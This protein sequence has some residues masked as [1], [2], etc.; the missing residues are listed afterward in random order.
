MFNVIT[1]QFKAIFNQAIDSLIDRNGLAVP[2]KVVYDS[3]KQSLCGN[4]LFDPMQHR[5][6]NKYNG[7]GPAPF[8]NLSICPVCNGLGLIDMSAE[9]TIYIA[10]IFDSKY[11]FNWDSKSVNI[12]NNMAQSI[13]SVSLLPKLQNSKEII[14]DTTI[15]G[16]GNRR[17]SR[18]NEP[19]VCGL[20]ENRYIITMWQKI[21]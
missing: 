15:A 4:C 7:T 18:V 13:C 19:E 3:L 11:W 20:G 16:Y 2:C 12:S 5:S 10:V 9:E 21:S 6:A 17:Y 8:G 14:I 1:P